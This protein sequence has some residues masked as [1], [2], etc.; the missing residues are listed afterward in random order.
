MLINYGADSIE[1]DFKE[2][3][4]FKEDFEHILSSLKP[5]KKISFK[6]GRPTSIYVHFD[7]LTEREIALVNFAES[8]KEYRNIALEK[9]FSTKEYQLLAYAKK[10]GTKYKVSPVNPL[11]YSTYQKTVVLFKITDITFNQEF[12][13]RLGY[14]L[15]YTYDDSGKVYCVKDLR[16]ILQTTLP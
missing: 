1:V 8:V 9:C 13:G 3:L 2:G 10:I 16:D 12:Y 14:D 6:T 4:N 5:Q 11:D 15:Q 7:Y